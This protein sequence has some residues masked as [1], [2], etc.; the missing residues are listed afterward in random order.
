MNN[1]LRDEIIICAL[2]ALIEKV[3]PALRALVVEWSE[4]LIRLIA[5]YDGEINEAHRELLSLAATELEA[6]LTSGI[7]VTRSYHRVDFPAD[8][9]YG[10]LTRNRVLIYKRYEGNYSEFLEMDS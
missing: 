2:N 5:Y 4:E 8:L 9:E 1:E 7:E 10:P 3:T 6:S